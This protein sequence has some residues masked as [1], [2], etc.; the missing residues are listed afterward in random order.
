VTKIIKRKYFAEDVGTSIAT[1]YLSALGTPPAILVDPVCVLNEWPAQIKLK[2]ALLLK[3]YIFKE[4]LKFI[5]KTLF[6]LAKEDS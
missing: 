3:K 2:A 4:Q 6:H 1:D 5:G